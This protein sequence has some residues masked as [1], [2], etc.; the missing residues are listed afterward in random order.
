MASETRRSINA[1]ET[2]AV[3]RATPVGFIDGRMI[4]AALDLTSSKFRSLCA[5][6]VLKSVRRDSSGKRLYPE[7][8]IEELKKYLAEI[9]V[10]QNAPMGKLLPATRDPVIPY[11][12]EEWA[13]VIERLE[14]GE[15]PVKISLETKTHP[16]VMNVI[17]KDYARLTGSMWVTKETVDALNRMTK[18]P[19]L[20]IESENLVENFEEL[21][22]SHARATKCVSCHKSAR[23]DE[24]ANCQGKTNGGGPRPR[25][26]TQ[27][28]TSGASVP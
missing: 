27:P 5:S 26:A 14:R 12:N 19:S 1:S 10:Q 2:S 9:A 17:L 13:V 6:G 25:R 21:I 18:L 23:P 11:S 24:C 4:R 28:A 22:A 3:K 16:A 20:P 8:T 7:T 15:S